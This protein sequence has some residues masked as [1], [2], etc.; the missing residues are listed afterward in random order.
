MSKE[1]KRGGHLSVTHSVQR[2][3]SPGQGRAGFGG[4]GALCKTPDDLVSMPVGL[5]DVS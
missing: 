4:H 2:L 1:V 3:R 5:S